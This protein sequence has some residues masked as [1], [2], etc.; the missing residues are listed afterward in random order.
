ME[1]QL[2]SPPTPNSRALPMEL[3]TVSTIVKDNTVFLNWQTKTAVNSDGFTIENGDGGPSVKSITGEKMKISDL[4]SLFIVPGTTVSNS[5]NLVVNP[6]IGEELFVSITDSKAKNIYSERLT[7][8]NQTIISM[9]RR[10]LNK[11]VYYIQAASEKKIIV[12]TIT[13]Q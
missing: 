12:G 11:G 8:K 6:D 5:I 4:C 3:L 13:V 7:I 2:L 1:K 10:F 9:P